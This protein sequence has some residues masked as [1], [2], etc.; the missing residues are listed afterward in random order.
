M[1]L[2]RL[3]AYAA[4]GIIGGLLIENSAL[5]VKQK[6]SNK[7]QDAKDS[8]RKAKRKFKKELAHS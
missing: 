3:I 7:M 6:A 1:K 8:A 4:A 5:I 2:S